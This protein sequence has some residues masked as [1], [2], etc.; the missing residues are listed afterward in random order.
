MSQPN[1]TIR[2]WKDP[3]YRDTLLGT[4]RAALP[5]HPAGEIDTLG[6]QLDLVAGGASTE[7]LLTLGC[8]QGLTADCGGVTV[9][10]PA[11]IC[12]VGCVTIW[13]T[14]KSVCQLI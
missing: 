13:W 3:E 10:M 11:M 6:D 5:A 2:A 8:C 4:S 1:D 9:Q 7:Y 14:T 12:T